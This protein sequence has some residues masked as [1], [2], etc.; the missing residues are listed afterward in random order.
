MQY[1][2]LT[3]APAGGATR[4]A[5]AFGSPARASVYLNQPSTPAQPSS[6]QQRVGYKVWVRAAATLAR[7]RRR[8]RGRAGFGGRRGG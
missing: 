2:C 1:L 8:D 3:A 6:R 4:I 7:S 5:S